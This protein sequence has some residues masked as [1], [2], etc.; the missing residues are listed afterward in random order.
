MVCEPAFEYKLAISILMLVMLLC[1]IPMFAFDAIIF[2][3]NAF[4]SELCVAAL[5][6]ANVK[7]ELIDANEIL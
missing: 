3:R 6:L 5:A 4:M 7:A 1:K 2:A